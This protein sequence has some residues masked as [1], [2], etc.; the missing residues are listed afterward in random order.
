MTSTISV[1]IEKPILQ[2]LIQVEKKWH[3]DRSEVVRR[4]LDKALK[5]W[6][7][8]N[9]LELLKEHKISVG[10]A[11]EDCG[12]SLWEMLDILKQKNVDWTAYSQKDLEKDLA[13]LE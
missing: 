10:K 3:T 13:L 5:E 8:E 4:L 2:A 6:K 11:A 1:R 7:L 12:I 9:A